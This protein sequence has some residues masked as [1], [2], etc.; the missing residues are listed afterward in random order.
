LDDNFF[1]DFLESFSSE[2][3][4]G[5]GVGS[6]TTSVE[7]G[8]AGATVLAASAGAAGWLGGMYIAPLPLTCMSFT[9]VHD[10]ACMALR[11]A[12]T[13]VAPFAGT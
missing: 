6:G 3:V 1:E 7:A 13:P 11:V 2:V 4:A 5:E 10:P 8:A 9:F 12:G